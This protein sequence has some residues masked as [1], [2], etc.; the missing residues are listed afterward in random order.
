M[1]SITRVVK[2]IAVSLIIGIIIQVLFDPISSLKHSLE[3]SSARAELPGARAKWEAQKITDYT[4]EIIGNAPLICQPSAI[5]EVK[6]DVVVKVETKDFLLED[7]PKYV[8]APDKWA[9]PDWG[10]EVFLC[11]YANFTMTQIFDRLDTVLHYTPTTL[12]LVDFDPSQGFITRLSYGLYIG[13]GLL[14]PNI[15]DCCNE[16]IVKN[17]Q[18]MSNQKP[19]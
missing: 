7:S 13:N 9:D 4:F 2:I 17:F 16:L 5:I 14:R 19:P 10:E 18:P 8:L 11:N 15:S 6:N 3:I 1:S 12:I